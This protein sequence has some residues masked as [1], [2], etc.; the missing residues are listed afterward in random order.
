MN[1]V[2]IGASDRSI[3]WKEGKIKEE[4]YSQFISDYA[5]LLSKHFDNLIV[6][7]DDGIYSDIAL[8][9]GKIKNKKPIGYYPDKDAN[10]G[11]K[12]IEQNFSKYDLRPIDGDW[13][14]LGAD[15]T[16]QAPIVICVGFTPGSL[17]EIAYL[18][19][20]QK[21]GA[22]KDPAL[23][24]IHLFI[25]KRSIGQKLPPSFHEQ[26]NNIFYFSSFSDLEKLIKSAK[27]KLS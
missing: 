4:D 10:F 5:N 18:K 26:I 27:A 17:I 8:E 21:Y 3:L 22:Y 19:Y 14:K 25:D 24:N 13:Y 15:L 9:F 20:H 16:K 1:A 7:P 23:K 2:I 11:I 6:T 12:H